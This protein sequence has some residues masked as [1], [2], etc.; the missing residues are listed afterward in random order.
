MNIEH[1]EYFCVA[2]QLGSLNKAATKLYISQPQLGKIISGLENELDTILVLRTRNGITLTPEGKK[3]LEHAKLILDEYKQLSAIKHLTVSHEDCSLQV[4]MVRFSH[5]L[6]SFMDVV[7]HHAGDSEFSHQLIEGD[8]EEVIEDVIS[9]RAKV[10][11]IYFDVSRH[12]KMLNSFSNRRLVYETLATFSPCILAAKDH[13]LLQSGS[14]I[15]LDDLRQYPFVRFLGQ[16]EDFTN[17]ILCE[18]KEYDLN[19]NPRTIY[20]SSRS[21]QLRMI[22]KS[23]GFGI[24][25]RNF[26]NQEE[27]YNVRS[28]PIEGCLSHLEFGFIYPEDQ[29]V[30]PVTEE[31]IETTKEYFRGRYSSKI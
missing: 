13:P 1:L 28:I 26:S 23:H 29:P 27:D 12:N 19:K 31:F 16:Y 25:I 15:R 5:I 21:A 8:P 18:D 17:C 14:R 3:F 30:T 4:S 24:G 6:E 2:A 9:H 7:N 20:V 11:I 22:E 10:G